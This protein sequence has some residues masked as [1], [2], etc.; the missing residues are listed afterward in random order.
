MEHRLILGGEQYLPFARSRIKAL[1]ATGLK[2]ASQQFEVDGVSIKVRIEPEHEYISLSGSSTK[3]LSGVIKYGEIVEL[4]IPPNS[5]SGTLPVKTLRSYKPTQNA[6]EFALKKDTSKSPGYF[7]DEKF[8]AGQGT[9][10]QEVCPSMFSG[11]IAKA[12]Q[13]ILAQGLEVKYDYHWGKCHGITIDSAGD[14]WL[15]EISET[16]GII[17]MRLP[18]GKGKASSTLDAER[19]TMALFG[20]LPTGGTFPADAL[21][22]AAIAAESVIRLAT[23]SSIADY[24]TK[25]PYVRN[26]GWSFNDTGTE[27][28]NTCHRVGTVSPGEVYGCH[29]K[30]D[31][32][33]TVVSGVVSGDASISLVSEGLFTVRNVYDS[34]VPF[35]FMDE[36]VGS[37]WPPMQQVDYP[38]THSTP[39]FVCHVDGVLEIVTIETTEYTGTHVEYDNVDGLFAPFSDYTAVSK[40]AGV[41]VVAQS[42]RARTN[43]LTWAIGV[44]KIVERSTFPSEYW[45]NYNGLWTYQSTETGVFIL[46]EIVAS[47]PSSDSIMAWPGSARDSYCF[48]R[49]KDQSD[50]VKGHVG[51]YYD[52]SQYDAAPVEYNDA[53]YFNYA[54]TY[55]GPPEFSGAWGDRNLFDFISYPTV[56]PQNA[57]NPGTTVN[58]QA[59]IVIPREYTQIWAEVKTYLPD[60]SVMTRTNTGLLP[61]FA[62]LSRPTVRASMFGSAPHATLTIP[63][64]GDIRTVLGDML[65]TELTPGDTPFYNFIGYIK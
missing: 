9:Q 20:G 62:D 33:I 43:G 37:V 2:Y 50:Q 63:G 47:Y 15:V 12:V 17:A 61:G 23:A 45:S 6:W 8:L 26:M 42:P 60:G 39:I 16:N 36:F 4:P 5:P 49:G 1:R 59:S 28:H 11:L 57:P 14:P 51:R 34:A 18:L 54:P 56:I 22:P 30:V 35:S 7:S 46:Q 24:F 32:S 65:T 53:Q 41:E 58:F 10:Y 48:I 52:Q 55:P 31:L 21:I 44:T 38:P 27:A 40:N 13:I 3:I 29:Y 64:S 19:R 25:T